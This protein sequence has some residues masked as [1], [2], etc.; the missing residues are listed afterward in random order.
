MI[1]S[2]QRRYFH[3]LFIA[4]ILSLI[5]IAISAQH[6]LL[7]PKAFVPDGIEYTH[8]N[9]YKI[10]K[11]SFFHLIE[12]KDL[13]QTYPAEH[14]DYYKYSPAF[15][16]LMA[17]LAVLPDSIGLTLW[18][19][20]NALVLFFALWSLGNFS[21]KKRLLIFALVVVELITSLQNSQSNGL[22][23]GLIIIAFKEMEK[24]RVQ[25]AS[26]FIVTTAFIKIFGLV[27]LI[28]FVFYP[29]KLKSAL[30]TLGWMAIFFFMPLLVTSFPDLKMQYMSWLHLL[31][32]D[33]SASTGLSVA[34][35]LSSWF[36]VGNKNLQ[37]AIGTLLLLLPLI[38]LKLYKYDLFRLI[39]LSSVLVWL[40]I[41][42]HKAESP[43]F[44]VAVSGIAIWFFAQKV[45]VENIVLLILVIIFTILSPTDIFLA[46]FRSGFV[47]PYVLKVVPCILVWIK[48]TVDLMFFRP[49]EIKEKVTEV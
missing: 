28:L 13:Y 30:Y 37:L 5:V 40:V 12:G 39:Y 36:G 7:K 31:Q 11:Q 3:P 16:L 25:M 27:A 29:Q 14:W 23:A 21:T 32:N 4:G 20:L 15:A 26:L 2:K 1:E 35:W 33:H 49:E 44:V 47:Q 34:G 17:P 22:I 9:N 24:G 42:N 38:R 8:Y 45:S 48:I 19:L 41:F 6:L 10:F 18:N 46:S 43:T